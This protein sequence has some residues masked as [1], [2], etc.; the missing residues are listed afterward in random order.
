ML[1]SWQ[2][3]YNR[4]INNLNNID[5]SPFISCGNY[6]CVL[7]TK[8]NN[9]YSGIDINTN[10]KLK[11]SAEKV[12]IIDMINNGEKEVIKL[13]VVNELEEIITP[14]EET[15]VYLL[16]LSNTNMDTEILINEDK[17]IKLQELL[18]DWWGTYRPKK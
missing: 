17:A 18:P 11:N 12:A 1:K 14:E 8:D 6:S 4:A 13:I 2:N 3:L 5:L 16:T 10:S 7:K 9:I 15:L